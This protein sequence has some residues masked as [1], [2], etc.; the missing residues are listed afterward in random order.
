M[1]LLVTSAGIGSPHAQELEDLSYTAP[2]GE[3]VIKHRFTV[4][5]P[6]AEVWKAYTTPEGIRS[7]AA[8]VV[9]L[10]FKRGGL[11]RTRYKV[12]AKIG[13]PGTVTTEVVSYIPMEQITM[14]DHLAEVLEIGVMAGW[15]EPYPEPFMNELKTE[16]DEIFHTTRFE[17]VT[18][19]VTRVTTYILGYR[20]GPVWDQVYASAI[21]ADKWNIAQL[22]KRFQDGPVAWE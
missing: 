4:P 8:P 7:W 20:N 11:C 2:G 21:D 13:E 15:F 14:K 1:G 22:H 3:R 12:G 19:S 10:D 18:D 5:A 9:E 17:V 6:L 16:G